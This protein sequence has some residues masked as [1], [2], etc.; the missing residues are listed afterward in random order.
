[1]S[2]A[3]AA[4]V[5][6][7]LSFDAADFSSGD[8]NVEV[9]GEA[10]TVLFAL[11]SGSFYG[12]PVN[13]TTFKGVVADAAGL[14][15][16]D[17]GADFSEV[18]LSY[19]KS[20]DA[21]R[22]WVMRSLSAE[23]AA[24]LT[25]W[26]SDG[27]RTDVY[28]IVFPEGGGNKS[29][30]VTVDCAPLKC[31]AGGGWVAE[32]LS[33]ASALLHCAGKKGLGAY[34][35]PALVL[36]AFCADLQQTQLVSPG[37]GHANDRKI[38]A[39]VLISS[40]GAVPGL[41]EQASAQGY[42]VRLLPSVVASSPHHKW[43]LQPKPLAG[44]RSD[45]YT[46]G[47]LMRFELSPLQEGAELSPFLLGGGLPWPKPGSA[48]TSPQG[49]F[50]CEV[51]SNP[52][53]ELDSW[54]AGFKVKHMIDN[55]GKDCW[56][57]LAVGADPPSAWAGKGLTPYV[58]P[59]PPRQR[60]NPAFHK[61][62]LLAVTHAATTARPYFAP[63]QCE[64]QLRK[65][66][67]SLGR[68]C[69][70]AEEAKSVYDDVHGERCARTACRPGAG[71]QEGRWPCNMVGA[72]S[73]ALMLKSLETVAGEKVAVSAMPY[74]PGASVAPS[75][76]RGPSSGKGGKDGKWSKNNRGGKG[77]K[78]GKGAKGGKGG[79]GGK[80]TQPVGTASGRPGVE[81]ESVREAAAGGGPEVAGA[82]GGGLGEAMELDEDPGEAVVRRRVTYTRAKTSLRVLA[83]EGFMHLSWGEAAKVC[84]TLFSMIRSGENV[85]GSDGA[86]RF[87]LHVS[88]ALA[89]VRGTAEGGRHEVDNLESGEPVN[90]PR[91]LFTGE[92]SDGKRTRST[93]EDSSASEYD[94]SGGGTRRRDS[95]WAGV[96]EVLVTKKRTLISHGFGRGDI[97]KAAEAAF[98]SDENDKREAVET[99]VKTVVT[100]L[101]ALVRKEVCLSEKA[102]K[103]TWYK[104]CAA[105]Y[106]ASPHGAIGSAADFDLLDV[107][108]E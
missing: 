11:S 10:V 108:R 91:P 50:S 18:A 93:Y 16:G 90:V 29:V 53:T 15:A 73:R 55:A 40:V 28:Q 98:G 32:E 67:N 64:R 56:A 65:A 27:P 62:C 54:T 87:Q 60:E 97:E 105:A 80:S 23:G 47:C 61:K 22:G 42:G 76:G 69:V 83:T 38:L 66:A 52:I 25:M 100:G 6:A 45:A 96:M 13:L 1:M 68:K 9:A 4:G 14:G 20:P 5:P 36:S 37:A 103:D 70:L 49:G 21:M 106:G 107:D 48:L 51:I 78:S 82:A 17:G 79:K 3:A 88:D 26:C 74:A 72:G 12:G 86:A 71:C 58:A 95:H 101:K 30:E 34:V 85:S 19:E 43:K 81:L 57:I 84:G 92:P 39:G 102:G 44:S 89:G 77:D 24:A 104:M 7:R 33:A 8:E 35:G 99:A 63:A 41:K 2:S 31:D 94:D 59:K 46:E 75:G